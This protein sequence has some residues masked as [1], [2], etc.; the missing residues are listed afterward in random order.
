M[1]NNLFLILKGQWYE[2]IDSGEKKEEYR[3]VT[4]YWT[5]RRKL[6]T[7]HYD[8]ATFQLAYT[9]KH[10]MTFEIKSIEVRTGNPAW[11]AEKGEKY[12]VIKLGKRLK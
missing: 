7:R 6:G 2:M 1:D 12:Y 4:E 9:K 10:R 3:Q 5:D 8:T 11:G